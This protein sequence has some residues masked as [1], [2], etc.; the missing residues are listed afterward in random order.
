MTD[1]LRALL[2]AEL[3]AERPPPL[4]DVVTGA[5]RDGRRIRRNRRVGA[6]GVGAALAGVAAAAVVTTA[7]VAAVT[8]PGARPGAAVPAGAGQPAA[9]SQ[10]AAARLSPGSVPPSAAGPTVLASPRT[11]AIHSGTQRAEGL[12]KKATSAAMLLLLTTLM[13]PGR[14]SHYAVAAGDDLH[15][16]LYLDDGTGPA[17]V[18]VSVAKTLPAPP[19]GAPVTATVERNPGNCIQDTT[20]AVAW[21]DGTT[22]QVDVA[23]CLAWDGTRNPPSHR[24]LTEKQA[25]TVAADPRWGVTMDADLLALGAKRFPSPLPVFH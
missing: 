23:T 13:P 10:S 17:M 3:N 25:A 14:T 18:R 19:V 8:H 7:G 11:L 1:E 24:A 5:I 15:V 22:V 16:Q 21:P 6:F 2:R 20:A 4:A 12:Q 9:P